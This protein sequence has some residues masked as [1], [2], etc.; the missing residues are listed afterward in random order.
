MKGSKERHLL[1]QNATCEFSGTHHYQAAKPHLTRADVL[2]FTLGL[3]KEVC[4]HADADW[5]KTFCQSEGGERSVTGM[6]LIRPS[7]NLNT[8][9]SFT[10]LR[11]M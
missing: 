10:V 4:L 2:R 8:D 1:E 11:Q 6:I 9:L 5:L 7:W 3:S